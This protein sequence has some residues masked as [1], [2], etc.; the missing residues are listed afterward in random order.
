MHE[1]SS[2]RFQQSMCYSGRNPKFVV[3]TYQTSPIRQSV[4]QEDGF[5][6]CVGDL[7][8]GGRVRRCGVTRPCRMAKMGRKSTHERLIATISVPLVPAGPTQGVGCLF[9]PKLPCANSQDPVQTLA[10]GVNSRHC[11]ASITLA[12]QGG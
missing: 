10:F 8:V 6:G 7:F 12:C 11:S 5:V 1:L 2:E 9:P 4:V 3:R